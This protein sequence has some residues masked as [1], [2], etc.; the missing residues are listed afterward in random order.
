MTKGVRW[1]VVVLQ[2]GLVGM[3]GFIAGFLFCA[4]IFTRSTVTSQLATQPA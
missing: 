2:V 4:S 3:L 1:R